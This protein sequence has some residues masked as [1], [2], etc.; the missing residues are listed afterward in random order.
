M[1]KTG[2]SR[3]GLQGDLGPNLTPS[4]SSCL[5]LDKSLT[6]EPLQASEGIIIVIY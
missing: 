3:V 2:V 6:T 4:I 5:S 1:V